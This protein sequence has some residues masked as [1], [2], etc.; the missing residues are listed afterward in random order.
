ME[1]KEKKEVEVPEE[2]S[3]INDEKSRCN[4]VTITRR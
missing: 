1:K 4:D 3:E 2:E